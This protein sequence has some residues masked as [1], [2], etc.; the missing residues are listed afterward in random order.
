MSSNLKAPHVL[1]ASHNVEEMLKNIEPIIGSRAT[2]KIRVEIRKNV[3]ALYRLGLSHLAF[4]N[5]ISNREWRQKISRLYYAAYNIRRAIYLDYNGNFTTDSSDHKN[6]NQLPDDFPNKDVLG[7]KLRD[8]RQDRN[9]CDY[10]H[11]SKIADLIIFPAD[12]EKIVADFE[13]LARTYLVGR[14]VKI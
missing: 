2:K 13:R 11:G 10:S 6:V 7:Q 8:L 5:T 3:T 9:L 12:A 14:G 4:A 1:L